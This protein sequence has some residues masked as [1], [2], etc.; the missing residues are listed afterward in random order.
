MADIEPGPRAVLAH[1]FPG[2][3]NVGD[4]TSVDWGRVEPVDVITAEWRARTELG[5]WDETTFGGDAA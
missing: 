3:P 4:I 2:V 5:T 1:R